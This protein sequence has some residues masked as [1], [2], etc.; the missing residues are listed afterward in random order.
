MKHIQ[1]RSCSCKIRY[2]GKLLTMFAV[3][4]NVNPSDIGAKALARER[5]YRLRSMIA[6]WTELIETSSWE[7]ARWKRVTKPSCK[8][9]VW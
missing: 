2:F 1:M 9:N 5:L 8:Q 3:M 7:L 4:T 6:M